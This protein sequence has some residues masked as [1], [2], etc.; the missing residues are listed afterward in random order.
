MFKMSV[1]CHLAEPVV[2]LSDDDALRFADSVLLSSVLPP[3]DK[4]P[5][6]HVPCHSV[7]ANDRY[8]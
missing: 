1:A 3:T 8:L 5:N 4:Q 6:A 2:S 7:R